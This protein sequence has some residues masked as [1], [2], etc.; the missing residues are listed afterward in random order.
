[1]SE[2]DQIRLPSS[3]NVLA[4][5]W[6]IITPF[7]LSYPDEVMFY[8]T[9]AGGIIITLLALARIQQPMEN[10]SLSR[11]N[12]FIG[13]ALVVLPFVAG[14]VT[15]AETYNNLLI[16]VLVMIFG[17]WS[18]ATTSSSNLHRESTRT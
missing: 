14:P 5:L 1:M 8:L 6:L 4:G 7:T 11:L 18:A 16:G 13:L 17:S 9:V 15:M 3:L 10:Q 12:V 2:E